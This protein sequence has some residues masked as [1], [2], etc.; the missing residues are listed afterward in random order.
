MVERFN[1]RIAQALRQHPNAGTN[2]G[3]NKFRSTSERNSF[4]LNFVNNYNN[5]RLKVLNYISPK[6]KKD[7]HAELYTKAGIFIYPAVG[8]MGKKR[9]LPAQ[10]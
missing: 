2:A 1:R 7:N 3:K 8:K 5:T 9:F 10:E 6:H 4:L